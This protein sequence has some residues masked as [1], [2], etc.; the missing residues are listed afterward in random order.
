MNKD[1]EKFLEVLFDKLAWSPEQRREAMEK[2][3]RDR[4]KPVRLIGIG[5]TGVGKT[6][7][8]RSIFRISD[9]DVSVLRQLRTDATKSATKRFYSFR[10]STDFGFQVEFTDGPGL[11]ED[12]QLHA[13]LMQAWINEIPNHDLLYWV[14]DGSSRDISHIQQNMKSILD[15]TGFRGRFV[16][17]INKVDKIELEQDDRDQGFVGW[18]EDFNQ[19]TKKLLKQIKR[20]IGDVIEKFRIYAGVDPEHIV[21]CSALKRWN[22]DL[23]LDKMLALL[24]P[25]CRLKLNENRD[26]K[27]STELMSPDVRRRVEAEGG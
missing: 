23:V 18:N 5:Q 1:P 24:P 15:A 8:L 17:V 14:L 6:E 20:R 19:P 27:S 22:H 9:N 4:D 3:V 7:L 11:G 10:I 2:I 16:L 21:V 25:E 12:L 26:V 13:E